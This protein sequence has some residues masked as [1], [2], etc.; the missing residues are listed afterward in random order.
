M[1]RAANASTV[2]EREPTDALSALVRRPVVYGADK[3]AAAKK[4]VGEGNASLAVD[5]L[6]F[7]EEVTKAMQHIFGATL[8]CADK[9][10]ARTVC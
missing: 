9:Q 7:D 6:E 5:L 4:L 10:S 8:V 3:V 2:R 1:S